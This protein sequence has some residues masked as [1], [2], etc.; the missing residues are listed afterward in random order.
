MSASRNA[1]I[2][3]AVLL[4]IVLCSGCA[5]PESKPRLSIDAQAE[6]LS[7]FSLGLLAEIFGDLEAALRHFQEAIRIDPSEKVLYPSAI[8][9]AV[10]L[11]KKDEALRLARQLRKHWP[12]SLP[13]RLLEAQVCALSGQPEEAEILFREAALDFPEEADSA[14]SLARFLV[15]QKKNKEAIRT[16]ES[17]RTTHADHA[18]LL[19]LLGTLYV[20][21]ARDLTAQP[22]IQR[23]ILEGITLLEETLALTPDNPQQWQQLGY[24]CLTVKDPEKAQIAFE[25]AYEL[26]PGDL[27]IARQLLDVCILNNAIE[28][29]LALCAELPRHTGTDPE[30]WLQ[31]LSEKLPEEHQDKLT[32]HLETYLKKH[33]HASVLYY[34]QLGSLYLDQQKLPEAEAVLQKAQE[35]Y[36]DNDRVRTVI[37]YLHLQ[38]ERYEE[39]YAT[40]DQV[41]ISSPD[42][43]WVA[44][45]FFTFNFMVAAQKSDH[46]EDAAETLASSYTKDPVIL[47]RYMQ[48]LLTGETPVSIQ[49]AIDLLNRFHTISPEASETLYYLTLLQADQGKFE[50][51]LGNARRFETLASGGAST[52]LLDGFFYYQ[53]AAL[54][55]RTGKFDEA[56][57]FFRKA[58]D[59]GNPVTVA[60][61]QNYIA[62]MWAERGEK[63]E[64]SLE[65][66]QQA[67]AAEPDNAA[68]ID[69]LG[70]IYYMQG[71]YQDA[72]GPLTKASELT[73]DDPAVWEHLGDAY[74]KLGDLQT[75]AQQW[76]KG[77]E[78]DPDHDQ[79]IQ[80]L[81]ENGFS[82]GRS[83]AQEDTP[84]D[85]PDH[86]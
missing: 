18:D 49:S 72:L 26:L 69:T 43:E 4:G 70:W 44:N 2:H 1:W 81:E 61:A 77:L 46:L 38:L 76:E 25:K 80:R 47:N 51:A 68:F 71:R 86:P 78:I 15:A 64:M 12:D 9:A 73:R 56:E 66:I 75:A 11:E 30:L 83:P 22:D 45:P 84:A 59:I 33:P 53:Y 40:F 74:L 28:R 58:I 29:A 54:H 20:D 7:H 62:Y 52:H 3:G 21:R 32:E 34:A 57:V 13:P 16:L 41:R 63:L 23:A 31:Y 24:A 6:A 79:L 48:A 27:H 17:A 14:I 85:T 36:P 82:P 19:H 10:Q 55:E 50:E 67:L 37:G 5:T 35:I 65:L 8:S 60:S 39:A 42:S